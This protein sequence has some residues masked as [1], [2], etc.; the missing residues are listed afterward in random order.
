MSTNRI[1]LIAFEP[2]NEEEKQEF[3]KFLSESFE[4]E[5][6]HFDTL[7]ANLP[8][9]L[10]DNLATGIAETY[11][12]KLK[13]LGAQI[14]LENLSAETQVDESTNKES[15][16]P[17]DFDFDFDSDFSFSDEQEEKKSEETKESA[18]L[19]T[20]TETETENE[21]ENEK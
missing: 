15:D 8:S 14:A 10:S 21:N 1:T 5:P 3:I 6:A 11:A 12:N 18:I 17:L 13:S 20:E 19:E 4:I 7:I 9:V 16:D 2:D